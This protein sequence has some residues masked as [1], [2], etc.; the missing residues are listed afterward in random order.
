MVVLWNIKFGTREMIENS[1]SKTLLESLKQV[2]LIT[3]NKDP[4][5]PISL[6][7]GSLDLYMERLWT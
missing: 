4:K 3:Q 6:W 7:M 1:K 5:L 2:K